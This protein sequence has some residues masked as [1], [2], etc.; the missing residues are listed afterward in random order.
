MPDIYEILQQLRWIYTYA[1]FPSIS[2]GVK[3]IFA[4]NMTRS[5][6]DA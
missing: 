6:F 3:E 4:S 5:W 2:G 1:R